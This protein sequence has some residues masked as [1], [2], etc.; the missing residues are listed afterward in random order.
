MCKK[1]I[2]GVKPEGNHALFNY[3]VFL[4]RNEKNE[5]A[6]TDLKKCPKTHRPSEKEST[7]VTLLFNILEP[8][9]VLFSLQPWQVTGQT[10]KVIT[11]DGSIMMVQCY[12]CV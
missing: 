6:L 7:Q 10:L 1:I 4:F 8:S 9:L 3:F 11:M 5:R 2:G 12:L